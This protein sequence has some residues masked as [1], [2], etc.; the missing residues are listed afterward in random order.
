MMQHLFPGL[1]EMPNAHPYFVHFPIVLLPTALLF[2][3]L[4]VVFRRDDL[5]RFG[6]WLLCLGILSAA[7]AVATGLWAMDRMGHD[8]PGH[9]LVHVHRDFMLVASALA[10]LAAIAAFFAR[11]TRRRLVRG[12][13]SAGLLAAVLVA[14]LGADRGARLV[15]VH[16]IGTRKAVH[17][18]KS[19]PP[20]TEKESPRGHTHE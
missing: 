9:D 13:L 3:V 14:A 18:E 1:S 4:A 15:Y 16:G 5:F 20:V 11:N 7:V 8:F 19:P 10:A 6:S 2:W 12:M 17:E